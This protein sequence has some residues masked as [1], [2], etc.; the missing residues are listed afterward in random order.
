MALLTSGSSRCSGRPNVSASM[1]VVKRA[2][3]LFDRSMTMPV[4]VSGISRCH[5]LPSRR[6]MLTG[7]LTFR[8]RLVPGSH[9]LTDR[10]FSAATSLLLN[11]RC[12]MFSPFAS[13]APMASSVNAGP[14][15]E[16]RNLRPVIR[17]MNVTSPPRIVKPTPCESSSRENSP[18]LDALAA[19]RS[20]RMRIRSLIPLPFAAAY[21]SPMSTPRPVDSMTGAS[22]L[23]TDSAFCPGVRRIVPRISTRSTAASTAGFFSTLSPSRRH[24]SSL[25]ARHWSMLLRVRRIFLPDLRFAAQ[26]TMWLCK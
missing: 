9:T 26:M 25:I 14:S 18:M 21:S 12:S 24:S 20:I 17:S 6:S 11:V 4:D 1:A 2:A 23:E 5:V 13:L 7:R 19:S 16:P 15:R 3:Y 10:S 22:Y 8:W